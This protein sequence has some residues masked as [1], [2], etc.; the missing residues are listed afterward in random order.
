MIALKGL[1]PSGQLPLGI[2][3]EGKEGISTGLCVLVCIG[4]AICINLIWSE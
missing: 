2:L 3:S 4:P 1:A